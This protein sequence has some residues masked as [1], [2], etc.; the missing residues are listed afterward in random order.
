MKNYERINTVAQ[1]GI[2]RKKAYLVGGGIA[3]LAAAAF[4]IRD[5]H[6]PPENI[7]ILEESQVFGGSMDGAGNAE[8]GY[9]ARGGRELESR[10]ECLYELYSFIPSLTNP[11]RTVLDEF[12]ELN[13]A[14][15]IKS[16]CRLVENKGQKAN[17]STL[18]LEFEDIISLNKLVLAHDDEIGNA[19]CEQWFKPHFFETN[20]WYFW[21]SMFAFENW[22]SVLEVKR[23]MVRFMHLI[24]GM[25]QLDGILHTEYN[26]YDSLILPLITWLKN[27]GVIMELGVQVTNLDIRNEDNE[28]TVERIYINRNGVEEII[29][30][31]SEDLVFVTNGSMTENST[32]GNT[33][34]PA[35]LNRNQKERGCWTLWENIAKQDPEF[36][37]P[38]V[39][40]GDIDKSKW[41]SFTVTIT[42]DTTVFDHL[43]NLTGDEPGMGGVVTIKDSNWLISWVTPKQPHFINQPDNV[44]VL[45]AYGLFID[46]VG[47]F[48]NKKMSDCTGAE[49][50][51]ELL[52]HMGLEDKIDEILPSCK[53]IPCIMPYITSQFMPRRKGDRPAVIP[54]GSTNLAFLGQFSEIPNDCVFTVEY[55]VRSAIMAVYGLLKLDKIVPPVYEGQYDVRVLLNA[56]KTMLGNREISI[57]KLVGKL[58]FNTGIIK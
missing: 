30:T 17:F 42:D 31:T 50:L 44:Q 28:K 52:Y 45:W 6:M 13:I 34:T 2:E 21:R 24:G 58:L 38:E 40:C 41:L 5:G 53:V 35:I 19:T 55:S 3:S 57:D 26:Q 36:G 9:S 54:N 14:E 16:H 46:K 37:H 29:D 11:E 4:L 25:N 10:M 22:H 47:N 39:F 7:H 32:L 12:R 56:V 33:D 20:F 48:V 43:L 18:G 51:S 1:K 23:Y 15:P 49:L 27:T 8:D